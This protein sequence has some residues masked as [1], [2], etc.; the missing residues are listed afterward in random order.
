MSHEPAVESPGNAQTPEPRQ[1]AAS[2]SLRKRLGTAGRWLA[3]IVLVVAF[4][5]GVVTT[6]IPQGRGAF[7]AAMLLPA[8]VFRTQPLPLTFTGDDVRH[9]SLTV[10]SQGGPVYLASPVIR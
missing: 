6:L 1:N 2:S 3:R 9:T 5:L 4:L 10:P 7:R 8:L